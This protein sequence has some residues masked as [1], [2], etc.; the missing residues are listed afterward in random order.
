MNKHLKSKTIK[1]NWVL[2]GLQAANAQIHLFQPIVDAQTFAYVSMFLG[3]VHASGSH[4]IRTIT[5]E[6]LSDK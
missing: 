2:A 4:Y 5:T 6:A 3:V 1:W